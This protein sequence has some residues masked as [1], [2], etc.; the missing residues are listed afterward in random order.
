MKASEDPRIVATSIHLRSAGE[1]GETAAEEPTCAQGG[2]TCDLDTTAVSTRG[3][4]LSDPTQIDAEVN[5]VASLDF[6]ITAGVVDSNKSQGCF[7]KQLPHS[8]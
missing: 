7:R 3:G 5:L 4:M 1:H 8:L 2:A 6:L